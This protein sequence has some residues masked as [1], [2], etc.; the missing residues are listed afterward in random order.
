MVSVEVPLQWIGVLAVILARVGGVMVFAPFFGS[1]IIPAPVRAGLAVALSVMLFPFLE[2]SIAPPPPGQLDFVLWLCRELLVGLVLGFVGQMFFGGLQLAG[3]IMGFQMGFSVVNV[4]DPQTQV[5]TSVLST[6]QTAVGVL[7]FLA[8]NGHHWFVQAIVD[9]YHLLPGSP[10]VSETLV[11]QLVI[12]SG[13]MFIL[14]LK[15][16]APII[17]CLFMVDVLLGILGRAAPQIHI[18]IVGMPAK[19]LMGFVFLAATA[20]TLVPFLARHVAH[21][22]EDLYTYLGILGR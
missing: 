14:G 5:E 1:P 12:S 6:L 16:A 9:S 8:V 2:G 15:L 13:Q 10:R 3:Q 21:L 18:L 11:S 22:H 20:H 17:V 19:S 7:V 4:I